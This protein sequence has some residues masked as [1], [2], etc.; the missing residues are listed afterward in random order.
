MSD[1]T[2]G[3]FE[4]GCKYYLKSVNDTYLGSVHKTTMKIFTSDSLY[5]KKDKGETEQWTAY[6][7]GSDKVTLNSHH[8][9]GLYISRAELHLHNFDDKKCEGNGW[10]V[11]VVEGNKIKLQQAEEELT[12]GFRD[13]HVSIVPIHS[14]SVHFW[15]VEKV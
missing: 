5:L 12:V 15:T 11:I 3:P 4:D 14:D 9:E 6:V 1:N 2:V 8:G 10:K 7:V 13:S